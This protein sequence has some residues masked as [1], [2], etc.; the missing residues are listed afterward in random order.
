MS[1]RGWQPSGRPDVPRGGRRTGIGMLTLAVATNAVAALCGLAPAVLNED[2]RISQKIGATASKVQP[3]H[4]DFGAESPSVDTRAVVDW[5]ASSGNHGGL[6]FVVVDK[7][8]AQLYLF[9]ANAKLIA[10]T[11]VLLGE[12]MG[13]ELVP[14]IGDRPIALV[15]PHERTTPAGRF[16]AERGHNARGE[17]VVW[18]DYAAAVSMHRVVTNVPSDRRLQRLA[19]P[20]VDDNRISYGCINVPVDFYEAHIRPSFANQRGIVYVLPDTLTIGQVF[21]I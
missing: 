8:A 3:A 5:I 6:H 12:A 2:T 13:D 21:G 20:T 9:N 18:V 7:K 14:G 11:P 17:D 1:K 4:A 10:A 19:S 15:M 16:V